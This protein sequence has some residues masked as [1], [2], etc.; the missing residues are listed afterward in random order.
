MKTI[1]VVGSSG[2]MGQL[3]C[4]SLNN[5]YNVVKI[6][7]DDSQDLMVKSDLV[8]DFSTGENAV[9]TALFCAKNHLPLIIGATGQTDK[10]LK[11]IQ[12]AAKQVPILKVGNFALGIR[13]IKIM[14][15]QLKTIKVDNITIIEYHH[16]HKKDKPSGTAIE[17]S[18]EIKKILNIKPEIF[19]VRGGDEIG[20]HEV[21]IYFGSEKLII[22]H[23]AFSRN[24]FVDGLIDAVDVMLDK[25]KSGIYNLE[26]LYKNM[27]NIKN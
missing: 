25:N 14:L 26:T 8:I 2:K 6:E 3:I 22:S 17:L 18:Q 12:I 24:A 5:K 21:I 11:Q 23:S 4:D 10:Q 16:K 1:A 20:I 9:N 19:S 15:G 7:K 13:L 27:K